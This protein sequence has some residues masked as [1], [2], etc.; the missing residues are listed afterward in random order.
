MNYSSILL[1]ELSLEMKKIG[2]VVE[3]GEKKSKMRLL[4]IA[5]A[6]SLFCLCY[7]TLDVFPE[8]LQP[9]DFPSVVLIRGGTVVNH[10]R[11]FKADV[12]VRGDKIVEIAESID[13]K[14]TSI[15]VIDATGKYVMPGGIGLI[16][17]NSFS[18]CF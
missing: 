12:L 18:S 16:E 8:D 13:I 6:L 15:K 2:F 5:V 10:D 11:M 4:I 14:D 1:N 3:S 9:H 17:Q 7:C